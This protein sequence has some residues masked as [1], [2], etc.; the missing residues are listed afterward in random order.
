MQQKRL[1]NNSSQPNMFRAI[2]FPSSVED[3]NVT[4]ASVTGHSVWA[5]TLLQR[6]QIRTQS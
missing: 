1:I 3:K 4:A 2:I 6:G 5:T